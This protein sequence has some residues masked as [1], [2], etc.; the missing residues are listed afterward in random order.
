MIAGLNFPP[1]SWLRVTVVSQCWGCAEVTTKSHD[2]DVTL[3]RYCVTVIAVSSLT[4][5][6]SEI[7]RQ[8]HL[9]GH[10]DR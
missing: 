2:V 1:H 6:R 9:A 10:T 5:A 3:L 8:K 4:D 7:M